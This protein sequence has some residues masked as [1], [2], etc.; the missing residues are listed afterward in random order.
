MNRIGKVLLITGPAGSGKSTLA[1]YVAE[2]L[3][4]KYIAEDE[5]WVSNEWSGLRTP[6][7]ER[8]VQQ[9]VCK[10]MLSLTPGGR[11]VVL[12][13][14]LY[15]HAPN[16]L[17]NYRQASIHN[18]IANTT[19]ILSPSVNA[20]I[21]R[22]KRRGRTSDLS[23]IS[24]RVKDAESQLR[25]LEAEYIHPD[26]VIDSSNLTIEQLDELCRQAIADQSFR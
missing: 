15:K 23:N 4:W 5:Y 22:M 6:H 8:I 13:F 25:C 11:S 9:H 16:A 18:A 7:Q 3:G 19:I 1:Y 14:I 20:I 2:K 10:D 12:E 21:E 24:S 17:T 26:W